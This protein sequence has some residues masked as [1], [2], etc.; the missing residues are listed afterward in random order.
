MKEGTPITVAALYSGDPGEAKQVY[1]RV[2]PT[3]KGAASRVV[4]GGDV[5]DHIQSGFLRVLA[6]K[7]NSP[8]RYLNLRYVATAARTAALS[9][10][11]NGVARNASLLFKPLEDAVSQGLL[12][13]TSTEGT[14][15]RRERVTEWLSQI[16]AVVDG[17]RANAL[18]LHISGYSDQEIATMTGAS[19]ATVRSRL[20]RARSILTKRYSEVFGEEFKDDIEERLQY[21]E[22]KKRK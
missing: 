16:T 7:R 17:E 15:G 10:E 22:E 19:H 20:S 3:M 11:T 5:S 2:L 12:H 4:G 14:S 18:F 8:G 21:K 1:R 6:A 13:D 9:A